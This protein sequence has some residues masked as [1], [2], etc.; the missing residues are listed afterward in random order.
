MGGYGSRGRG[1][2]VHCRA[3]R[4]EIFSG[5]ERK[6]GPTATNDG[7]PFTESQADLTR[8]LFSLNHYTPPN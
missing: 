2:I 4:K 8:C 6:I 7:K 5:P 3:N 1:E